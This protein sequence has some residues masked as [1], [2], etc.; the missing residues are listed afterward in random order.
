MILYLNHIY[1][2]AL[3]A[4][5]FIR[6]DVDRQ[7]ASGEVADDVA[8]AAEMDAYALAEEADRLRAPLWIAGRLRPEM[9][10]LRERRARAISDRIEAS[11]TRAS[12]IKLR[13]SGMDDILQDAAAKSGELSAALDVARDNL[14]E[15]TKRLRRA[16][17][18]A[19][20]M[21]KEYITVLSILV[22]V[23]LAFN[24]SIISVNVLSDTKVE[25]FRHV[26]FAKVF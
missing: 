5:A 19:D 4:A 10:E 16:S 13:I 12:D 3:G 23:V 9:D 20:N 1:D 21:K 2:A 7:V 24:A 18:K 6:E 8:L 22:A 26:S 25:L 14:K 11:D 17:K 15:A